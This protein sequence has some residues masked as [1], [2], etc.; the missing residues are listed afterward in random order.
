MHISVLIEEDPIIKNAT[1]GQDRVAV[2]SGRTV[3]FPRKCRTLKQDSWAGFLPSFGFC[4][5]C[6]ER[7]ERKMTSLSRSFQETRKILQTSCKACYSDTS[8]PD[9]GSL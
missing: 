6:A 3:L 1:P 4:L 5:N 2:A 9:G 7:E 8:E